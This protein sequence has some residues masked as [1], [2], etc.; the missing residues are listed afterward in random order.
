MKRTGKKTLKIL[1]ATSMAIFTLFTAFTSAYA[2]FMSTMNQ[3]AGNDNFYVKRLD[4]PVTSIS[5]HEFYGETNDEGAKSF[6]FDPVGVSVYADGS[7]NNN[8]DL[9]KLNQYI[10]EK[11]NHPVLILFKNEEVSGFESQINLR[12]ESAYLG[13]SDDFLAGKT[14]TKAELTA[15]AN[16][17]TNGYYRVITDESQGDGK[18]T[19]LYQYNG[20]SLQSMSF[21]TY[22][23]LDVAANRVAANNNKYFLVI[24]DEKHGNTATIYQYKDATAS[25]EMVWCDLGNTQYSETNPL[26]SAVQFHTFTFT[27]T[28]ANLTETRTVKVETFDDTSLDYTYLD[29][30]KSCLAIAESEFTASNKHSFTN[31]EDEETFEYTKQINVFRGDVTGITYIGIVVDYDKYALEYIFSHNLGNEALN[32]GLEFKCDWVTEF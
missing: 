11:P 30:S 31:F 25:F 20:S 12:T 24:D 18:K 14:N 1:A 4:T 7:F 15:L 2:W 19:Y 17:T 21:A 5:I 13:A 6:A 29:T 26:S 23:L 3:E 9:V 8:A 10:L 28:L 27:D 16:K 32:N 22:A